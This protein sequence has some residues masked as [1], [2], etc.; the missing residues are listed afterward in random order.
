MMTNRTKRQAMRGNGA[1]TIWSLVQLAGLHTRG[2]CPSSVSLS[3]AFGVLGNR[4]EATALGLISDQRQ[5][6]L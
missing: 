2:Y 4:L 1:A 3:S 6:H 5:L